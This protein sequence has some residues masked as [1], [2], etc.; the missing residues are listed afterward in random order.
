MTRLYHTPISPGAPGLSAVVNAP[1]G[2]LD[3]ALPDLSNLPMV[4]KVLTTPFDNNTDSWAVVPGLSFDVVAD[5]IYSFRYVFQITAD[6]VDGNGF[7]IGVDGSCVVSAFSC[8]GLVTDQTASLRTSFF[9]N[10]LSAM[11]GYLGVNT[12]VILE[13]SLT[14]TSA[15]S[16]YP[17]FCQGVTAGTVA[18]VQWA[19][20]ILRR[21]T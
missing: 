10:T 6:V 4:G 7:R 3:E 9:S 14:V 1:L 2:Q 12:L 18:S 8:L 20:G 21:Q 5:R 11:Q 16:L 19:S 15:G 17:V 13:G